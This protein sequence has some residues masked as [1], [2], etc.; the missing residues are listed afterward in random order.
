MPGRGSTD[1]CCQLHHYASDL[2]NVG[3]FLCEHFECRY[4]YL[5]LYAQRRSVCYFDHHFGDRQPTANPFGNFGYYVSEYTGCGVCI[6]WI[7]LCLV[8]GNG[9]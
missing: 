9:T 6:G 7:D 3:A 1:T 8:T 2:G 5:H 4:V